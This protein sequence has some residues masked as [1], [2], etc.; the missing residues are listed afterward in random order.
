L[1]EE[2][3]DGVGGRRYIGLNIGHG[4][5]VHHNTVLRA[6]DFDPNLGDY[7]LD[8]PRGGGL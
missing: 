7:T 8:S 4:L 5:Q 1:G 2:C 3:G 6:D